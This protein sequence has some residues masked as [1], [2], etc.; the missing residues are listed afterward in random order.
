MGKDRA[1]M[2]RGRRERNGSGPYG[3]DREEGE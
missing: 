2:L 1:Q 3:G